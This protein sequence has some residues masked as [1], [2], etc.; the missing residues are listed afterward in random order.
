MQFQTLKGNGVKDMYT[1]VPLQSR[2][3]YLSDPRYNNHINHTLKERCVVIRLI[4]DF[5]DTYHLSEANL[6]PFQTPVAG[7]FRW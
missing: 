3:Q 2:F 6:E 1:Q 7:I 5:Q 4:L